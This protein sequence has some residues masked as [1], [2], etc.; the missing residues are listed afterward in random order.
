MAEKI[1]EFFN[2][3]VHPKTQADVI[4]NEATKQAFIK[5]MWVNN[6]AGVNSFDILVDGNK[7]YSDVTIASGETVKFE[8]EN[9]VLKPTSILSFKNLIDLFSTALGKTQLSTTAVG[10]RALIAPLPN[11]NIFLVTSDASFNS[12]SFMITPDGKV[13]KEA[14]VSAIVMYEMANCPGALLLNS[15]KTEAILYHKAASGYPAHAH[16][17]LD[18]SGFTDWTAMGGL[19]SSNWPFYDAVTSDNG[20]GYHFVA[21]HSESTSTEGLFQWHDNETG[22]NQGGGYLIG[23]RD[24][25]NLSAMSNGN[26]VLANR[27]ITTHVGYFNIFESKVSLSTATISEIQFDNNVSYPFPVNLD[28]GTFGIIFLD[29]DNNSEP[30]F[31]IYNNDGTLNTPAKVMFERG[32]SIITKPQAFV[33]ATGKL[34]FS[35]IDMEGSAWILRLKKLNPDGTLDEDFGELVRGVGNF[36]GDAAD[37]KYVKETGKLYLGYSYN[38]P[39]IHTYQV[40]EP[41]TVKIDGVEVDV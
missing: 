22:Q 7:F 2:G 12:W 30:T 3:V 25:H 18:L 31:I 1:K 33:M 36:K 13:I 5:N 24:H 37:L 38:Y 32:T 28:N 23:Y 40:G 6:P 20:D 21:L 9:M 16:V 15:G 11:G 26:V 10:C 8:N 41:I 4:T 34:L 29:L 14:K 17:S 39:Y 19:N 27:H 35:F